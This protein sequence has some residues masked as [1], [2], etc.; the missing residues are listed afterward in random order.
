MWSKKCRMTTIKSYYPASISWL[1]AVTEIG[2]VVANW[3]KCT[4]ARVAMSV[5]TAVLPWFVGCTHLFTKVDCSP[6]R[7]GALVDRRRVLAGDLARFVT[8]VASHNRGCGAAILSLELV[9]RPVS[10]AITLY[11]GILQIPFPHL[12]E[13]FD[14]VRL[15][16]RPTHVKNIRV[17][18]ASCTT[19]H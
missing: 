9:N 2:K 12:L 19:R 5:G 3:V 6:P 1:F 10:P 16:V 8:I 11:T 18:C 13:K 7:S 15:A 17:F 4:L 14:L